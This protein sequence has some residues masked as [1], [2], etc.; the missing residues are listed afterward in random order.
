M[1][2]SR[3]RVGYAGGVFDLFH[4][5]HL[6]V[7]RTSKAHCDFLVAGVM[8]DDLASTA[9]GIEPFVPQEERLAIVSAITH[10]DL[11]VIEDEPD[12]AVTYAKYGITH[13]FKGDDWKGT[14]KGDKLEAICSR[15]GIELVYLPYTVHTSSTMLRRA[16]EVATRPDGRGEVAS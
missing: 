11:A 9:K 15:M 12:K 10:V 4:V 6:N 8:A 5:G 1:T 16:L 13:V 3:V 7:L 14:A 2:D